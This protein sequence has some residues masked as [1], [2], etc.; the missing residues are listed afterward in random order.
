MHGMDPAPYLEPR[1]WV[2]F[3]AL[4]IVRGSLGANEPPSPFS[5][6]MSFVK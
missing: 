5:A 1:E 6:E 2:K 3:Q 4:I